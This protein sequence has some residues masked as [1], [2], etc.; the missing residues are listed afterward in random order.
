M[1]RIPLMLFLLLTAC[2]REQGNDVIGNILRS[3]CT[4]SSNCNCSGSTCSRWDEHGVKQ[5]T[6]L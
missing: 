2:A 1:K 4:A 5:G 3:E 6:H